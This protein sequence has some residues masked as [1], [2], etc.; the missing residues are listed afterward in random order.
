[1]GD[2]ACS[3]IF[4]QTVQGREHHRAEATSRASKG[5]RLRSS[6]EQGA[7]ASPLI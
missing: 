7:P 2:D 1:M 4:I 5:P 6:S 3:G